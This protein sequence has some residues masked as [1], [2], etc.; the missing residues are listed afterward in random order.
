VLV[1]PSDLEPWGVVIQ[2]AMAAGLVIVASHLVG[3][4]HE[5]V[6]DKLSGRI[7]LAGNLE[8]LT[9]AIL[10]VTDPAN[11][12]TYRVESR[13]AFERWRQSSKPV[14]EIRRALR[15]V[16]VLGTLSGG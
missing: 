15:D 4:A 7:F 13:K 2:E 16:G 5:M 1:L 12:D 3:A 6:Q 14:Y 9:H 8:Q 11:I 10:D